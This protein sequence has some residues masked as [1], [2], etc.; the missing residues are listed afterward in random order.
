MSLQHLAE[1]VFLTLFADYHHER[2]KL[3]LIFECAY[4]LI[5]PAV[6]YHAIIAKMTF[7][8]SLQNNIIVLE[9]ITQ[10]NSP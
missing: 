2:I 6:L 3:Q 4:C 10:V 1:I 7:G 5:C 9:K 8:Y